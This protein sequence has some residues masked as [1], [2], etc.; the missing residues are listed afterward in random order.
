MSRAVL[1]IQTAFTGDVVLAL[2]L[3]QRIRREWPDATIHFLVRK[4]N[5][6]LVENH[7]AIDRVWIWDKKHN[8]GANLRKLIRDLREISFDLA[9][10]CQRFFSTGLLMFLLRAKVKTGFRENPMAWCYTRS[11]PH[12]RSGKGM[13]DSIH[14]VD[15]NL[16]LLT[17]LM[18]T[19]REIPHLEPT[20]AEMEKVRALVPVSDYL[21]LAP[22]SVWFTKQWPEARWKELVATLRETCIPVIIGGPGDRE[23]GD[24]VLGS[25]PSGINLCGKLT[26]RESA[27]LMAGARRVICNDSAPLHLA[28]AVGAP[29]TGIFCSTIPGFG[30][31]PLSPDSVI[32]QENTGLDCR[33]CGLHGKKSCPKGHFQCGWN[34]TVEAVRQTIR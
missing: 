16:S 12:T 25:H 33:P 26:F 15:R 28:S 29:V 30:F 31:Y 34:I 27:A 6:N 20:P 13:S 19:E 8:K 23:L 17:G 9:V 11:F 7:P 14:E 18:S 10:N 24:R 5:E 4:G 21:V 22:A 1:I 32:M 2:P 3:A